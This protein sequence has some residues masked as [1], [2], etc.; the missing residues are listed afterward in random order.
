MAE[1]VSDAPLFEISGIRKAF[2]AVR[3]LDWDDQ[4]KIQI[5]LGEV[6]AFAGENGAGKSTLAAIL[7]GVTKND[8]G[9]IRYR[10]AAYAPAS[11]NAAQALGVQIVFQEPALIPSLTVA[12]NFFLRREKQFR[13]LVFQNPWRM[14]A[15]ARRL[16]IDICPHIDPATVARDL[17]LEDQKLIETARAVSMGPCCIIFDETTAAMSSQNTALLVN[18]IERVKESATVIVVTHRTKEIFELTDKILILKDGKHVGVKNTRD[19]TPEELSDL[20]VGR[21][22]NLNMRSRQ[23]AS[24][25]DRAEPLLEVKSLYI[26]GGVQDFSLRL[27]RGAIIG[28]G[29]L[30]GAGQESVLRA[31]YG[32]VKSTGGEVLIKGRP[33][34]IR[35]PR[36][37]IRKG[38]SYSPKNRDREGLILRQKV[39]EN[40]VLSVLGR[41]S[42][43]GFTRRSREIQ[44]SASKT[45]QLNIK[46][47]SVEDACQNLSG[48]NRQKVVLAKLLATDAEIFL[49]DNPTRGIDIGA[50][51]E[52][53]QLM[54]RLTAG[55]AGIIMASDELQE[56]LQM[57]DAILLIK[58]GRISR[59]FHREENPTESDLIRHMI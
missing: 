42:M 49:L 26:D 4:A 37:S 32:L 58:D 14:V 19:T 2:G 47:R 54:N 13:Y 29:G 22:V 53:Y 15:E 51:A 34:A 27:E 24:T 28:I 30:A 5:K 3:A 41:M 1:K 46:C 48:G 38:I 20:M 36:R 45:K 35:S 55:G 52:I 56:L 9:T 23:V 39:R 50:R 21:N 8:G 33:Y 16:L 25:E 11:I 57:S 18:L 7:A 40:T 17:S 44:L 10:D 31:L 6:W 12:E 59:V 43:H